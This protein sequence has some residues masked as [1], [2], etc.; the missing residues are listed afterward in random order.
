MGQIFK[1]LG[2]AAIAKTTIPYILAHD[3]ADVIKITL[4][5]CCSSKMR[6]FKDWQLKV[7]L[8]CLE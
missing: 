2:Q 6:N 3:T 1:F 5:P 4:F 8:S 7:H